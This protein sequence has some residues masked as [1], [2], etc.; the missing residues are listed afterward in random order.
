MAAGTALR[1]QIRAAFNSELHDSR[2]RKVTVE[3]KKKM[4]PVQEKRP[5]M[6]ASYVG[7][8]SGS[9]SDLVAG[10]PRPSDSETDDRL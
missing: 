5:T 4:Y 1:M 6:Q 9:S 8:S 2:L 3:S 10:L 7:G